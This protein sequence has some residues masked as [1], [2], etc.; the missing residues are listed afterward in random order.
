MID[1]EPRGKIVRILSDEDVIIDLGERDGLH[2]GDHVAILSGEAES[3]QEGYDGH[4]IGFKN[5][6]LITECSHTFSIASTYKLRKVN[7]GGMGIGSATASL[8]LFRI[9]QPPKYEEEVETLNVARGQDKPVV[10][11]DEAVC[12]GD[13][14]IKV[15]SSQAERGFMLV[16]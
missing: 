9:T 3:I 5:T 11:G 6:L 12:V 15:S 10:V 7:R 14:V 4:I 16:D 13:S 2:E 1:I 8:E